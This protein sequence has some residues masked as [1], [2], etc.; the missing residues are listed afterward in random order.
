MAA[1]NTITIA[2]KAKVPKSMG[3][4]FRAAVWLCKLA[5]VVGRT[6]IKVDIEQRS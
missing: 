6:K 1:S 5:S 3:I 4:R 2:V